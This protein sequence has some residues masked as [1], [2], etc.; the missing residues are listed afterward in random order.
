MN[1]IEL[2][3]RPLALE[4]GRASLL[5]EEI[6]AGD[7]R[8]LAGIGQAELPTVEHCKDIAIIEIKGILVP[9]DFYY[10]GWACGYNY[11]RNQLA[12][13]VNDPTIKKIILL[14]DSPGGVASG[15]FELSNIIYKIRSVKPVIAICDDS[16]YSAAYAIASA[17]NVVTV[18]MAGG[19]GSIG[20]ITMHTDIT[21]ALDK[22]GIKITTITYG[23][24][25]GENAPTTSL[26]EGALG[27]IQADVDFLG[28]MFVKQVARNRNLPAQKIRDME[29]GTFLGSFGV[30]AGLADY[31]M[32]ADEAFLYTQQIKG[33]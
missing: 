6:M 12:N 28:E 22:A 9:G 26:T 32:S 14:I 10:S 30:Q 25:K 21:N 5:A 4:R 16:A 18:P 15:C 29:A 19:V 13:A 31:V 33:K 7:R 27:R 11:I 24:F 3:N 20:V 17:A 23:A 1:F 2:L 8:L